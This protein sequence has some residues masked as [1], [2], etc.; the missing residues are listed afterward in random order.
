MEELKVIQ[1][2]ENISPKLFILLNNLYENDATLSCYIDDNDNRKL[3]YLE[4]AG[5]VQ[6]ILR[7]NM[8]LLDINNKNMNYIHI[9]RLFKFIKNC[10]GIVHPKQLT[11]IELV[12]DFSILYPD[13]F[14]TLKVWAFG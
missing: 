6:D 3:P 11:N 13:L 12:G 2:K 7:L 9:E 5:D 14:R 1:L 8:A 10:E 4:S